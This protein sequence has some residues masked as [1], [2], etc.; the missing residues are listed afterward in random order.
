MAGARGQPLIERGWR[1]T[2]VGLVCATVN[3]LI[4]LA[5]DYLGGIY[6]LGTISAF[7]IVTPIGYVLHSL[8]TFREPLNTKAFARFAIAASAAF[9]IALTVMVVLCSGLHFSV[10]VATPVMTIVMFLW[11]FAAA[12]WAIL[13]RFDL[14]PAFLAKAGGS[15]YRAKRP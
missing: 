4:I 14:V 10:A 7:L 8:F 3:F 12:H 2:F 15:T 1:Y 6:L 13:P 9:P 5:V 11:N